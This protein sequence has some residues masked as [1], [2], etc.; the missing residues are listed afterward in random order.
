MCLSLRSVAYKKSKDHPFPIRQIC[1]IKIS[2][3]T[4]GTLLVAYIEE[5]YEFRPK[6]FLFRTFGPDRKFTGNLPL[7]EIRTFHIELLNDH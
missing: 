1:N 5:L 2:R 6:E 7:A 3:A 4:P